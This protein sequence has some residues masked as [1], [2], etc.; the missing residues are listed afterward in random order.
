M[1]FAVFISVIG[2]P[3]LGWKIHG[4][5]EVELGVGGIWG[6]EGWSIKLWSSLSKAAIFSRGTDLF[7]LEMSLASLTQTQA[8]PLS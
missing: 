7:S 5:F 6:R 2:L 4:D 3:A 1:V 8:F